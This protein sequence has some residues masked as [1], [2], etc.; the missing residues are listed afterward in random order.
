MKSKE[1]FEGY[2]VAKD[3]T[4]TKSDGTPVK[5]F[6]SNKYKQCC[7]FDVHGKKYV[8][9]V[10]TVVSMF[11]DESWY[12]GCVV[13]HKD[14]NAHNNHIDNLEVMPRGKHSSIHQKD[15]TY[16]DLGKYSSMY[17]CGKNNPMAKAVRC[18]ELNKVFNTAKEAEDITGVNRVCISRC[19][20][21]VR[22]IAGGYHWEFV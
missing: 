17:Q 20:H 18:I 22:K 19:C 11:H 3:G 9:G 1:L 16:Y 8:L 5:I 14:G 21:H 7:L 13:H 10:H 4:I 6:K 2:V 15:G 12:D